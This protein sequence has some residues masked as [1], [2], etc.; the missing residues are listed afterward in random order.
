MFFLF[1][2]DYSCFELNSLISYLIGLFI[3][4]TN[5]EYFVC[6]LI[7]YHFYSDLLVIDHYHHIS[8]VCSESYCLKSL[9]LIIT[10][11][12]SFYALFSFV[13]LNYPMTSW[14]ESV[15]HSIIEDYILIYEHFMSDYWIII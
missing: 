5:S 15:Y 12:L 8:I 4:F 14:T 1:I 13:Y 2:I 10:L 7:S 11:L 6:F 3:N 9:I